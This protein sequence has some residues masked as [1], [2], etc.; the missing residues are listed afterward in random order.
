MGVDHEVVDLEVVK[1]LLEA[2]KEISPAWLPEAVRQR[3]R[4]ALAPWADVMEKIK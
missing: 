2:L 1:P 3:R 4:E